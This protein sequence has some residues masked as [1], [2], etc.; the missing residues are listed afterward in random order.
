MPPGQLY[1]P[2]PQ[3]SIPAV[4]ANTVCNACNAASLLSS[5][6]WAQLS[7]LCSSS[8]PYLCIHG[9]A[10]MAARP[11]ARFQLSCNLWDYPGFFDFVPCPGRPL[12]QGKMG[13]TSQASGNA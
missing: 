11:F 10:C 3:G 9:S 8:S 13:G 5:Q 7:F 4:L 1:L 2:P 12:A 6:L